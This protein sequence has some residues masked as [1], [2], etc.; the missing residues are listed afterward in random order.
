M[1]R[2]PIDNSLIAL[3]EYIRKQ[4]GDWPGS[5]SVSRIYIKHSD[6]LS[7]GDVLIIFDDDYTKH[8]FAQI[9]SWATMANVI[10]IKYDNYVAVLYHA[11]IQYA[12]RSTKLLTEEWIAAFA[13]FIDCGFVPLDALVL[14]LA[15]RDSD[16]HKSCGSNYLT[17]EQSNNIPHF[18]NYWPF[19]ITCYP[20]INDSPLPLDIQFPRC[21]EKLGLYPVMPSAEWVDRVLDAGV[22]TVQLRVKGAT[23]VELRTEIKRAI[24]IG[25]R[26]PSARVFINDYWKIAA[27]EGAYGVHLGQEDVE[28]A[29]LEAITRAGM[30]IGLSSHGYYEILKALHIR[31]SYLAIGPVFATSTKIIAVPPQGLTRLSCYVGFASQLAPLVAIGGIDRST[32]SSVIATGVGS[33]AVVSAITRSADWRATVYDFMQFF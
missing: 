25:H 14:A 30:R 3:A 15:W 28:T 21:P 10:V 32:I 23:Q 13:A 11:G 26:Y 9:I 33:V 17:R 2:K 24:A 16:K 18:L 6:E 1:L 20:Q 8:T 31:P 29:D 12:L 5:S 19:D 22:V 4:L 27:D 7:N